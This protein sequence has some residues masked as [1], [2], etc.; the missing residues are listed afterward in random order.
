MLWGI[1]QEVLNSHKKSP[2]QL[3]YLSFMN[4]QSCFHAIIMQHRT[5]HTQGLL[6]NEYGGKYIG[7]NT[8][9]IAVQIHFIHLYS[10]L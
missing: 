1:P 5:W 9:S 2:R 4:V 7:M 6:Y 8:E 10:I 3:C